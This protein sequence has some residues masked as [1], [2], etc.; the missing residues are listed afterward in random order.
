[1]TRELE[2]G[3]LETVSRIWGEKAQARAANPIQGWLDSALVLEEIVQKRQTGSPTTNWLKGLVERLA[4]PRS[5]H[6]LS[7]GCGDAGA[8]IWISKLGLVGSMDARDASPAALETARRNAAAQGVTN[9]AF[10]RADL[11]DARL[12]RRAFDVV[13]M[14]MSL[15]HVKRLGRLLARISL[16]LKPGGHFLANEYVGPRQFQ[17][18]EA[19]LACVR[20]LLAAMPE[21][22]RDDGTGRP[23]AA[24][25]SFPVEHWNLH[26]PSESVRSDEILEAV[27]QRFEIV[28]RADYGGTLL[29]LL[30]EHIAHNF[31][32]DRP[33]DVEV[34]RL[35]GR[36][37]EILVENLRVF[38]NDYTVL[39]A[40]RPRGGALF[41]FL[42]RLLD[43]PK[44]E[45][46][47]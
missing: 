2:A 7:L 41:H 20:D 14:N 40:R 25:Q 43:D 30:L 26:D 27:A 28:F 6:W 12:P 35:L 39:A 34:L 19:R 31:H 33:G 3:E 17:F 24:Y 45:V 18:S 36:F 16:S 38:G 9:I 29:G 15:H 21:R 22:L 32:A 1:M 44:G 4:I 37:E 8:E 11:N 5:A 13:L 47:A 23:K 42:R 46:R 10:E